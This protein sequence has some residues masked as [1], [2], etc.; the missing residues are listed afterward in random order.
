MINF[1]LGVTLFTAIILAL[2]TVILFAR[3]KLVASGAVDVEIN[4]ER[5]IKA[6]VGSNIS[7]I[8]VTP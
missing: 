1:V 6:P 8:A 2:V 3:S 4:G 7:A 5:T